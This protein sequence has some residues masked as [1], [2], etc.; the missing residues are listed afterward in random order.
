[1]RAGVP[2]LARSPDRICLLGPPLAPHPHPLTAADIRHL[3]RRTGFGAPQARVTAL[4]GLTAA[5]AARRLLDEAAAAWV[6]NPVWYGTPVTNL[7][8][9]LDTEREAILRRMTL[10]PLREKLTLFWHNHFATEV[11]EYQYVGSGGRQYGAPMA[12]AHY[13]LLRDHALGNVQTLVREVGLDPAMLRYLNGNQSTGA[14][15]NQNYARE[16]LELFTMG[17]YDA[18][19]QANY[20]EQDV[21]E[22]ARSLTGWQVRPVPGNANLVESYFTSSRFDA[23][24]KTFLGQTGTW[25]HGHVVR[26]VFEQRAPQ[27]GRFLARKLLAFFVTPMPDAAAEAELGNALVAAN[28]ELRPVLET[29]LASTYFFAPGYRGSLV[30]S[31]TDLY[32]GLMV[33]LGAQYGSGSWVGLRRHLRAPTTA[34]ARAHVYFQP[35][36]VAGW[37]GHNPPSATGRPG[38]TGWYTAED[39]PRL[40]E[41]LRSVILHD[42]GSLTPYDPLGLL[43][44]ASDPDDAFHVAA[45]IAEHLFAVPLIHVSLPDLSQVPFGGDPQVPPPPH[46][47]PAY[48]VNLAKLLLDGTPHYEWRQLPEARRAALL[49]GYV[50]RLATEAPEFLLF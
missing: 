13:R 7:T 48:R 35:P 6:V 20:T 39:F 33:D 43:A 22:A 9:T 1:V 3:L 45:G 10:A 42:D 29:L 18:D 25:G 50:F 26:H 40:W 19:G 37:P 44:L 32:L 47:T 5:E 21:Q 15:P 28:F 27:V 16:L 36:D 17:I 8:T 2:D 4:T 41:A 38:Y 49:R 12:W 30:K 14:A 31:P 23:G 34:P 24:N 11:T 46:A